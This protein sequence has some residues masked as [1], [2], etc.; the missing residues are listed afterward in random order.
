MI[1]QLESRT[2]MSYTVIPTD[3]P[4]DLGDA[5]VVELPPPSVRPGPRDPVTSLE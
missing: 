1:E 4:E 5:P 3:P 2:L